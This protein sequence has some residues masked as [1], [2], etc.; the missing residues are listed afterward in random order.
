MHLMPGAGFMKP[1]RLTRLDFLTNECILLHALV[2]KYRLVRRKGFM[3]P[4][5]VLVRKCRLVRC[6]SFMKPAPESRIY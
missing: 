6:K 5:P 3:K 1:V 2:R 4:A